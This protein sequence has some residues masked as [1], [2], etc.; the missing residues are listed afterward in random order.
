MAMWTYALLACVVSAVNH[1][2]KPELMSSMVGE[3]ANMQQTAV[4][5]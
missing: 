3:G 4:K 2:F 5:L 1:K